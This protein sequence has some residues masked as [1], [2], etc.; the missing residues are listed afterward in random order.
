MN[1]IRLLWSVVNFCSLPIDPSPH[2][3][4]LAN[5]FCDLWNIWLATC[6]PWSRPSPYQ[7]LEVQSEG[8]WHSSKLSETN[9]FITNLCW[10]NLHTCV[11]LKHPPPHFP[12]FPILSWQDP[13]TSQALE[14]FPFPPLLL[15][16]ISSKRTSTHWDANPFSWKGVGPPLEKGWRPCRKGRHSLPLLVCPWMSL[17]P[18]LAWTHLPWSALVLLTSPVWWDK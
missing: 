1:Y 14:P 12:H 6:H 8:P 4:S 18:W 5:H 11:L 9:I 13:V 7:Q 15:K 2:F 10:F 3:C 17:S 16:C